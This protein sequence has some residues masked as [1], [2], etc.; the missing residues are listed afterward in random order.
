MKIII[1]PSV[2]FCSGVSRAVT[3][4]SRVLENSGT[5]YC[6]GEIIHNPQVVN[7]LKTRGMIVVTQIQDVPSGSRFIIRSHGLPLDI[8]SEAKERSL[9]I[10]DFTCPKVKKIHT[11]VSRL[12]D[13]GYF[14]YIAGNPHHP[15]VQAILSL[16]GSSGMVVEH[17]EDVVTEPHGGRAALVV[18]TTFNPRRFREIAGKLIL[19]SK[20]TFVYNT[21]CEETLKRQKE[22]AEL[23]VET[24][25][26]VVV[27]GKG[28][29]NT[30]TL[31]Q[32]ALE[33]T[34]A[35]HVEIADNLD[36]SLF[37]GRKHVGVV[38]GASTPQKTVQEVKERI[39]SLCKNL[40][41]L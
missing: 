22:T 38:S 40:S 6:L 13:E 24:D 12:T 9:K 32:I 41:H 39:E 2:G 31:F 36:D 23:A 5:T 14:C 21:L 7:E 17:E 18:Q 4:L 27:G 29:S 26:V 3:G 10:F 37:V 34:D 28:S 33:H 25:L 8:I 1:A 11:L 35:V 16:T 19:L 30:K 15:E 20:E